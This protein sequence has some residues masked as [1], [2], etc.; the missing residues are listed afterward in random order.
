MHTTCCVHCPAPFEKPSL[1]VRAICE[2]SLQNAE[3]V[4]ERGLMNILLY[5]E[6]KDFFPLDRQ[7]TFPVYLQ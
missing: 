7:R 6:Q 5:K 2:V 1:A 3:I 4:F